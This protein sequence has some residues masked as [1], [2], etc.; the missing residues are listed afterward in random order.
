MTTDL[1][2]WS[3]AAS[4]WSVVLLAAIVC[5]GFYASRREA[6]VRRGVR[7]RRRD[8]TDEMTHAAARVRALF[9]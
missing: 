4:N 5:F 3:A 9:P 2:H 6:A 8:A 7:I 1:S